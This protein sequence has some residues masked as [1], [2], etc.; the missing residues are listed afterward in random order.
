MVL[1]TVDTIFCC[2]PPDDRQYKIN[3]TEFHNP[4]RGP[5]R[6]YISTF[7]TQN[8]I[9]GYSIMV[10]PAQQRVTAVT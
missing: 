5:R 7:P 3:V 2:L 4:Y 9:G 8:I 1:E 10:L 6:V